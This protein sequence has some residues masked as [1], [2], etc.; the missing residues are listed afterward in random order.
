MSASFEMR[1]VTRVHRA[2][3]TYPPTR[4]EPGGTDLAGQPLPSHFVDVPW[5]LVLGLL[6]ALPTVTGLLVA[7]L[8]RSRLPM[9][10]ALS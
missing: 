6:V 1:D 9:A 2:P 8:T 5:L 7:A 3:I 10:A 4:G